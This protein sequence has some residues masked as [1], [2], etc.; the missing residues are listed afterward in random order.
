[1]LCPSLNGRI[2]SLVLFYQ[3]KKAFEAGLF[4][5]CHMKQELCS[6][7]HASIDTLQC[8]LWVASSHIAHSWSSTFFFFSFS[9]DLQ[10]DK[11]KRLDFI[12]HKQE[13]PQS[14]NGRLKYAAAA[15]SILAR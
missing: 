3:A 6:K 5:V 2:E 12:A 9:V 11:K 7:S 13:A 4:H 10:T 15:R 1:M 14:I 8:A